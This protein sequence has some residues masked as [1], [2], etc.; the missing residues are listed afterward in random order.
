MRQGN[1]IVSSSQ[2][3]NAITEIYRSFC[4]KKKEIYRSRNRGSHNYRDVSEVSKK[5]VRKI[6]ILEYRV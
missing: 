6:N 4:P 5:F 1:K 3:E 2:G